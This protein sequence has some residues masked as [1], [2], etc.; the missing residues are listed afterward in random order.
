MSTRDRQKTANYYTRYENKILWCTYL[1]AYHLWVGI[2]RI[3]YTSH[4]YS[5][6]PLGLVRSNVIKGTQLRELCCEQISAHE[7]SC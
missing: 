1:K 2:S 3:G 4:L 6:T 5:V 7:V